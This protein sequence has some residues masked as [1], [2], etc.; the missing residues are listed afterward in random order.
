[1]HHDKCCMTSEAVAEPTILL[2]LLLM[3]TGIFKCCVGLYP[4]RRSTKC[5]VF[6]KQVRELVMCEE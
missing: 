3:C 2:Q 4:G 5:R 1:M 6:H